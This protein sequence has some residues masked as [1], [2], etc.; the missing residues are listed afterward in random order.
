MPL[1]LNRKDRSGREN[2]AAVSQQ[3]N[4]SHSKNA[5]TSKNNF[6][7]QVEYLIPAQVRMISGCHSLETSADV[8]N[9][10]SIAGKGKLPS[11]EG[12]AGGACTTALLSILYDAQ[13]RK[14]DNHYSG[15]GS[16]TF[17]QLLLELR[18]RLAQTGMSQ[19][20]QLTSSRPLEL[21]ETPFSLRSIPATNQ[22]QQQQ[23]Q[24]GGGGTQRAL[25]VGINYYG[26]RG[27]LSGCINDVLNVKKYLCNYQGFL[28]KHVLLLIDDGRNHHPTRDNI[29][30]ALQ[31]LVK[32]SKPGD[33][34]YFHYSGHGGLLDPNYWN[35]YKAGVSNKKYDETL[36]PVDHLKAGQIRDFNL[37]NHFVKPMAAGVTVTCVMDCCH[38]GSVLD[39]PYSY[40]PTSD[41]TIRMRQSMDSLTNLA[42]LYILAGGMLPDLG[43]ESI[44]QNLENA[45]GETMDNLQGIGVEELSSDIGGYTNDYTNDGDVVTGATCDNTDLTG[46][47]GDDRDICSSNGDFAYEGDEITGEDITYDIDSGGF[48]VDGGTNLGGAQDGFLADDYNPDGDCEGNECDG[49]DV[50]GEI[51]N[52]LFEDS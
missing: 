51:L 10:H 20:S 14:N 46:I 25:L 30:R 4:P 1:R 49:C 38:S 40:R 41:G 43:F 15:D 42:F 34:V 31:R 13:K 23:Q 52:T 50:I 44:A 33:S 2:A 21:E 39:L 37:F 6:D 9:I 16:T 18:R 45:T 17:Q 32:Q 36:Y 7:E 22:Q 3:N 35:R 8:S 29:I 28:E 12:R 11:P 5:A 19:V 27:Q 24:H 26:Q 48:D 47:A